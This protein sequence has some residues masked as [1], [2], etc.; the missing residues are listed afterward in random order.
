[1][2]HCEGERMLKASVGD[3][4]GQLVAVS[5]CIK[6][7]GRQPLRT[8]PGEGATDDRRGTLIHHIR[9]HALVIVIWHLKAFWGAALLW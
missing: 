9:M 1:M 4:V 5:R 6:K 8:P 7:S 3:T 2:N